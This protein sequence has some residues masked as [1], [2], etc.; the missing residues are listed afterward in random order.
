MASYKIELF[1]I[2]LAIFFS[3]LPIAATSQTIT[4]NILTQDYPNA[5]WEIRSDGWY[6]GQGHTVGAIFVNIEMPSHSYVS[7]SLANTTVLGDANFVSIVSVNVYPAY[8]LEAVGS[9][10]IFV[11]NV[12]ADTMVAD[13]FSQ[14][15]IQNSNVTNETHVLGYFAFVSENLTNPYIGHYVGGYAPSV[16]INNNTAGDIVLENATGYVNDNVIT[17][18]TDIDLLKGNVT[19]HNN[20][21]TH[22]L[23]EYYRAWGGNLSEITTTGLLKAADDW[24]GN[25]IVTGYDA[26][27]TT[28]QLLKLADEWSQ[29]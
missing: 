18:S 7:L 16:S 11:R 28:Q 3:V 1:L 14:V 27:I 23:L 6:D 17:N 9:A 20:T 19:F 13:G 12:T 22:G 10:E 15:S 4:G 24:T 26:P 8:S 2:G 5:I 21:F 29:S 25:V